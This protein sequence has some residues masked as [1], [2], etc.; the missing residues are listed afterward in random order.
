MIHPYRITKSLR[1][2]KKIQGTCSNET[3]KTKED[4]IKLELIELL[5]DN[6]TYP[7]PTPKPNPKF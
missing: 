6:G 7:Y 1:R 5:K 4:I 3:Y 2:K